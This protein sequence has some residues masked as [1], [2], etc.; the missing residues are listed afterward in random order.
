MPSPRPH[1]GPLFVLDHYDGPQAGTERQLLELAAGLIDRGHQPGFLLLQRSPWLEQRFPGAPFYTLGNTQLRSA[2]FW[3]GAWRGAAWARAQGFRVAHIFFNDS[4]LVFP[5]ILRA[6]GLTVVQARRDVGLWYTPFKLRVLRLNRRWTSVV[7]ANSRAVAEA[8][9]TAEGYE[10]AQVQVIYNGLR[11]AAGRDGMG[12]RHALGL[13]AGDRL[14]VMVANL[15]P[16]K[17]PHDAVRAVAGLAAAITCGKV[18]L[19]LVGLDQG[20][21]GGLAPE[22]RALASELGIPGQVHCVGQV[23]DP[24][25]W[26][27]AAD[28]C[29]LCSES[30]G[31]SNALIEYMLAGKPVVCTDAGG[32]PELIDDGETGYL[33]PVGD[34]PAITDRLARLLDN[35]ADAARLGSAAR[36]RAFERFSIESMLARHEALYA[37]LAAG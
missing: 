32:N 7:V 10:P 33:V 23:S 9:G 20:A 6:H 12:V 26:V 30:E 13:G 2:A 8:V 21:G 17:R 28:A 16:L 18:H 19:A 29:L 37:Q 31:L 27:A 24:S 14:V 11:P 25:P 1:R 3:S 4:A 34:V 35:L 5:G 15:K 36:A 22:L